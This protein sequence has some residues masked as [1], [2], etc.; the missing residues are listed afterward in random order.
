RV[1]AVYIT[2]VSL[3]SVRNLIRDDVTGRTVS[4]DIQIGSGLDQVT[5]R[6][7]VQYEGFVD[8]VGRLRTRLVIGETARYD[9]YSAQTNAWYR[10]VT[11]NVSHMG[12]RLVISTWEE[13]TDVGFDVVAGVGAGGALITVNRA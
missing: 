12:G 13:S 5:C 10:V 1:P 4:P 7:P 6:L 8:F 9:L 2:P 11:D 3:Y